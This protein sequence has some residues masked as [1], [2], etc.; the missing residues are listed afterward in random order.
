MGIKGFIAKPILK[1]DIAVLIRKT[2]DDTVPTVALKRSKILI[3]DDD[4]SVSKVLMRTLNKKGYR[5]L[6]ADNGRRG[7]QM[8][9][10]NRPDLV[11][12]AIAT[13]HRAAESIQSYLDGEP[14]ELSWLRPRLEAALGGLTELN[15]ELLLRF[16]DPT[17]GAVLPP[18][19][20]LPRRSRFP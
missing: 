6:T 16:Y 18:S 3:V 14:V 7:L 4:R 9:R 19:R 5:V 11:I 15:R 13:A 20:R 1:R 2:L 10:D 17:E 8:I 12:T